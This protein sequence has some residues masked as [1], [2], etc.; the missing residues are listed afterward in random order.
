MICWKCND[1]C[2][3]WRNFAHPRKQ[4]NLLANSFSQSQI[5]HFNF[6]NDAHTSCLDWFPFD[7]LGKGCEHCETF[8]G[9]WDSRVRHPHRL[10]SRLRSYLQK[11]FGVER[12]DW[13]LNLSRWDCLNREYLRQKKQFGQNF[14]E[15]DETAIF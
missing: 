14:I 13:K 5:L 15:T 10:P 8:R 12:K 4:R 1:S 9:W 2:E 11:G 7:C 3:T 6:A